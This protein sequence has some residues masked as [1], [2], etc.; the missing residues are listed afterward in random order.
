MSKKETKVEAK[1]PTLV[2]ATKAL[3]TDN[4][5]ASIDRAN[6]FMNNIMDN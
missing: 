3:D 5:K 6:N 4:Y 2:K 1:K